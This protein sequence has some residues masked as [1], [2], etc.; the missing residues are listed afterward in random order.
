MLQ[1]PDFGTVLLVDDHLPLLRNLAFLL[2]IAGFRTLTATN[3]E[4]ALNIINTCTCPPDLI[5][6]DV[7][8]P[9]I[10]G[11]DLLHNVRADS[12][13]QHIPFILTSAAYGLEDML[14]GLDCGADDFVPKP[15]DLYDML[16]A[17]ERAAPH[18]TSKWHRLAS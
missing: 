3:G 18:L 4:E 8:M 11:F 12:R 6:S 2:D 13:W 14:H 5:I 16:D 15:F 17:I 7:E 10:N 9:F 1:D